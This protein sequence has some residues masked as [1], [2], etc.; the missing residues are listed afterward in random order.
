M[1]A[2]Y[3]EHDLFAAAWLRNLI[4]AGHI[5]PGVVDERDIRDIRPDELAGYTQCHFFAGIG[6]WSYALRLAGWPDDRPA[7]TGSCPCQPFSA[8]GARAGFADERHLWPAFFHLIEI[9]RPPIVFGEQVASKDGL[10]WLDLVQ[11]DLEGADYAVGAADLC[12][13]GVGAPHIRQR[14]WWMADA[15]HD[16]RSTRPARRQQQSR[17]PI[18]ERVGGYREDR[19]LADA[20]GWHA[21]A[22]RQQRSWQHGQQPQDGGTGLLEHAASEQVGLPRR[23][24]LAGSAAGEL[25]DTD[26]T[27]SQGRIV[28]AERAGELVARPSGVADELA[29][30]LPAGR[31]ERWPLAGN[32]STAGRGW[33]DCDWLPCRDGKARPVEPGTF[34]LAHGIPG[35]V[36]RLRAYGN[37]IVPQV[38]AQFIGAYLDGERKPMTD[39]SA[40]RALCAAKRPVPLS[41]GIAP[42]ALNATLF[43]H[44]AHG[45]EFALRAG[46][47]GL[48]Y[49]TGLGK[50]LSADWPVAT[51]DGFVAIGDLKPGDAVYGRFGKATSVVGV[52]PQG[53][54]DLYR[55]T[56]TD[57][58]TT[59]CDLDHLW[60]VNT[61]LRRSRGMPWRTLTLD[62]IASEGLKDGQGWRHFLPMPEPVEFPHRTLPIDPYTLGVLLGDGGLNATDIDVTTDDE[63]VAAMLLPAGVEPVLEVRIT[64]IVSTYRL[65]V[66][67]RGAPNALLDALRDLELAGKDSGGKFIPPVYLIA[68]VEQRRALLRG[69][70]DSDG[71][72]RPKDGNIEYGTISRRLAD[73]VADLIRS[74]GGTASVRVKLAP[75]YR[76]KGE[77]KTG[78][79]YYRMSVRLPADECPFGLKRKAQNWKPLTKYF[80]QR[81][82]AAID[83]STAGPAVCIKV[84]A[85]DGLFVIR[86]YVVTHNTAM[87][88]EWGR[89][90]VEHT[91]KPVLML[92]PLAVGAQH[93]REAERLGVEA[94]QARLA[95]ADL[96][97]LIYVTNYERLE[98]FDPKDFA[99][100]IL[101]ESSIL[102]SFSGVTTRK[103]IAAFADTPFRLAG[104]ATPAPN[105]HTELGQHSDF[106]GV[107]DRDEMLTRWFVHD[108][109]N[110]KDW[111][112]KRHAVRPFWDWVASWARCVAK[113]SDLGFSD[114]GFALPELK[115]ERHVVAAD[116]SIDSGGEKSGQQRLFRIPDRSAT[117]IHKEKRLTREDR[118]EFVGTLLEEGEPTVIWV[119]TDYDAEAVRRT[120]SDA[121]E[122]KG[123]M[124]IDQKEERLDAF[125]RGEISVLLTKPS[126]AGFGLNWQHCATTVFAGVNFSYE[127]FYQAIRRFWRYGQKRPV[128]AHVVCSDT[129]LAIAAVVNRKSAD[130]ERMKAEM[131]LAMRR[132]SQS[133]DIL[134]P[135]QPTKDARLPAWVN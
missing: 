116:R 60:T 2:Y 121:I 14:L 51:P 65:T 8:A 119:D 54:R 122:V 58:A 129:E 23:A 33:S 127:G 59:V 32:G 16:E 19:G 10:G 15:G 13:A 76:H 89:A 132:A 9:C 29:N 11:A 5:A 104:T 68:S 42:P 92:A 94:K 102:K 72:V 95:P 31:A 83:K 27:R 22:E 103:L 75:R 124:P 90:V 81:A 123:S 120:V 114:D 4:A 101:D 115:I 133:H 118:A 45:V 126:I 46:R 85:P 12:A 130:H 64:E 44:Q 69:L 99:G 3:N 50:A 36:G 55:V 84:S 28:H 21:S 37:A 56:F 88:L 52:F 24:R 135:Y 86:D 17:P 106:L 112:L 131:S 66:G 117:A 47:A 20:N 71:H 38:A 73:D 41:A 74:L 1:A 111:R 109:M 82:I 26:D 105:D 134:D 53:I 67:K 25:G 61:K 97:P 34:P 77:I 7:W 79:T 6:G 113:P 93:V 40:Y 30:T 18:G 62:Q 110:T 107:M 96:R 98:K 128:T 43:P 87:M 80:P 70:L 100:I 91:N 35:R 48:F 57:G 39:L 108:S 125:S 78:Q 49:D 63:I